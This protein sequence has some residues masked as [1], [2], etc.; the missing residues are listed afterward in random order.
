M[1][2]VVNNLEK[3]KAVKAKPVKKTVN[4]KFSK[5][6]GSSRHSGESRNDKRAE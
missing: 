6:Q 5:S 3:S 1:I 4:S 2:V